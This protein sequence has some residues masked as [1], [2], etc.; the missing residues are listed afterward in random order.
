[1]VKEQFFRYHACINTQLKEQEGKTY[2]MNITAQRELSHTI[3]LLIGSVI[4][5]NYHTTGE[6]IDIG[7]YRRGTNTDDHPDIDLFFTNIPHDPAQGFVDWT[8]ID[9]FSIVSSW[10]GIQ[11]LT[12]IQ[13]LDPILVKTITQSLQQ[14]E[15]VSSHV[16]FCG[17]KAWRNDPGVVFMLS[18]EHPQYGPLHI[19]NTLHYA[20][21]HFSVEHVRRFDNAIE[22]ITKRYGVDYAHQILADIRR[23]KKAVKEESK[24][25]GKTDRSKKVSGFVIE[26]LFLHQ[27]DPL[28]YDE[29]ISLLNNHTWSNAEKMKLPEHIQDQEE[30]LI[31]ANKTLN[32]VLH[33]ITRGGYETLKT[34]AARESQKI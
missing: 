24:Q 5:E 6:A 18:L 8:S 22:N 33:S 34:V 1:L 7:S 20:N 28:A 19:D 4:R 25:Q 26:A 29:V 14:V 32:D 3:A 11:D 9:T 30:Q 31:G 10:D 13:Q 16:R 27:P 23:L 21:N 2:M 15:T 12:A 17:V